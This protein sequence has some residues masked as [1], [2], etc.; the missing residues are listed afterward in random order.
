MAEYRKEMGPPPVDI[1]QLSAL[2][3]AKRRA[4]EARL[5]AKKPRPRK[6]DSDAPIPPGG[7]VRSGGRM[8]PR[9]A[10]DMGLD[11][12]TPRRGM[13]DRGQGLEVVPD[14]EPPVKKA[15]GGMTK[16]YA[17]GGAVRGSGCEQRGL[18]KCKVV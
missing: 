2:P 11:E 7:M 15:A 13:V 16:A 1:D 9:F 6:D 10:R 4:A 8:M 5:A 18:R 12:P 17:K 3:P 14:E